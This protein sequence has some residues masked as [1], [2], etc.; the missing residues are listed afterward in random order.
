MLSYAILYYHML[1][2]IIIICIL[3]LSDSILYDVNNVLYY[4]TLIPV[5]F[6]YFILAFD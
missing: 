1:S 2:Y 6:Y 4:P 5:I 3:K